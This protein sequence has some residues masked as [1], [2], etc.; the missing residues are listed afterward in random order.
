M[1]GGIPVHAKAIVGVLPDGCCCPERLTG[2]ELL[3]YLGRLHGLTPANAGD[4][5]DELLSVLDLDAC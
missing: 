2:R 3:T 5:A 4:R 1:S